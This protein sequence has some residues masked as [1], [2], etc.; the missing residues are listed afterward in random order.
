MAKTN[1][2]FPFLGRRETIYVP[3]SLS[4]REV[5]ENQEITMILE[6]LAEANEVSYDH[7]EVHKALGDFR[8]HNPRSQFGSIF[9][10]IKETAPIFGMKIHVVRK[11]LTQVEVNVSS[12]SPWIA[13]VP[14]R[15]NPQTEVE[16]LSVSSYRGG[17]FKIQFLGEESDPYWVTIDKLVSLI[18]IQS[19]NQYIRWLIA[20][21][22]SPIGYA[23]SPGSSQGHH[24]NTVKKLSAVDRIYSLLKIERKDIWIMIIYGIAV[25]ILSL[26]VPIAT[27]SLVNLVAFGVMLQPIIVLTFLVFIFLSFA[28]VMTAIQTYVAEIL[29]RRI[30]VRVSADFASR[31]P[32]VQEESLDG[33][34]P[35]EIVNRFFDTTTVQKATI[36]LLVDGLQI[37]LTS[38]I[39]LI[40]IAF[41][42][43]IFLVFS[44]IL[45]S[46]TYFLVARNLGKHAIESAIKVSKNKYY[47][48][49]WLQEISRHRHTF[50][51]RY[52][53]YFATE[54][55]DTL[56]R[57]YIHSRKKHFKYLFRQIIGLLGLQAI[58]SA[59][60]LG[61]GG[62][63]VINKQLTIGQLVAAELIVA[64]VLYEFSKFGKHLETFYTF[65]AALDKIGFVTDL[66][67]EENKLGVLEKSEQP[68]DVTLT[69]ITYHTELY[70]DI[71]H[72]LNFH[73]QGGKKIVVTGG[74]ALATTTL[75]DLLGGY[76]NPHYGSVEISDEDIREISKPELRS[77]ICLIRE[78]E[79]FEG[80]IMDNLKVGRVEIST[81]RI[82]EV[83]NQVGLS[84]AINNLH[85]GIHTELSTYG[86]P[87]DSIQAKQLLI[88]RALLGN[89]RLILI[90]EALEGID[91]KNLSS[92]LDILFAKDAPW[93]L[94]VVTYSPEIIQRSDEFYVM[95]DSHLIRSQ[96]SK[97]L[98]NVKTSGSR[99]K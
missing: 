68:L 90:D 39:G 86:A 45:L 3:H 55:A 48:G 52:G 17:K 97:Y 30:F 15:S 54:K 80:T 8:F 47:V 46:S 63:L 87:L 18:G 10:V 22:I 77:Q 71:F 41:Y 51:S 26:V 59:I 23:I 42:H 19:D 38:I 28:G 32:S 95:E 92:I 14:S 11:P 43:P 20:E 79:I 37:V 44:V 27:S 73:V 21:P 49:A 83:L 50:K 64:K 74:S 57:S 65:V 66:P 40:L 84:E 4:D 94:V 12:N 13:I 67:L 78:I 82:R 88:A 89:P 76:R 75:I 96:P 5:H 91:P 2:K 93:T 99:K 85:E 36:T 16:W 9:E 53:S 58:A 70:G 6:Y 72:N 69:D 62:Y 60:V 33:H 1:W 34:H 25:G 31:F 98:Q 29:Q 81:S 61:I 56:T 24:G 7:T 35:P